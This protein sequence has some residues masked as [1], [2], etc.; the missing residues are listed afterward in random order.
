M[1]ANTRK[2]ENKDLKKK[3]YVSLRGNSICEGN[4]S[5]GGLLVRDILK[6]L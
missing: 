5:Q 2:S 4:R 3:K 1:Y 6:G